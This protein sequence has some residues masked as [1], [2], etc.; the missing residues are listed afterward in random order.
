MF[1]INIKK[2]LEKLLKEAAEMEK[3]NETMTEHGRG[4]PLTDHIVRLTRV[5]A[6]IAEKQRVGF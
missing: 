6:E 5:V 1:G 2:E 4:S 3:T